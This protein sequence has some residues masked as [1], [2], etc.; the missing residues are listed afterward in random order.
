[1]F[2]RKIT[3]FLKEWKSKK[4]KSPLII[5]GLRQIGKTYIVKE[6]AKSEYEN[7]FILDFRKSQNIHTIFDGDFDINQITLLIS[8]LS[9]EYRIIK[10]SAMVPY[11]TLIVFDELQ[12]CPNA[13]SSL[14]YF[15]EDGRFDIICTGSLMGIKGYIRGND[16]YRG[17]GVGSEEQIEMKPMDFEEFLWANKVDKSTIAILKKYYDEQKEIPSLLHN[18]FLEW[19]KKYIVVGG[20]PYIVKTFVETN[21]IGEVRKEQLKLLDNYKSDFGVHINNKKEMVVNELEKSKILDVFNS[22]PRQLAKENKKF[23]Y[24]IISKHAKGRSHLSA[25][26]WLQDY[27]L[28]SACYNLSTI[29]EP[30]SFFAVEDQFKVYVSDIGLLSAMLEKEAQFKILTNELNIGKGMIYENLVADM[31]IKNSRPLYYFSKDSGLEIDFIGSLKNS[32]CLIEVKAKNG[33]AKAANTVLKNDKYKA[34]KIVKLTSQNI[35]VVESTITVP[36]YL[37]FYI[38]SNQ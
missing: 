15:K 18:Q 25:I 19:I 6:F 12:D 21:D 10:S 37:A 3:S 9:D 22:I 28:I 16:A 30:L 29:E 7:A 20:L 35:S 33:T 32:L 8:S 13:R 2:Q 31:M 14:K 1:M 27:G 5:R 24:S 36:Y 4:D 23:M 38:F 11:K 34:Q 26:S 17:I